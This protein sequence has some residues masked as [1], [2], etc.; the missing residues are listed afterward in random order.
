MYFIGLGLLLI[1]LKLLEVGPVANWS[2]W[3]VLS[4][5]VAAVVWWAWADSTGY[6]K[7]REMDK[8]EEKKKERR[9]KNMAALG[10]EER[11]RR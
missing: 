8:I 10:Q 6:T 9:R 3:L 7:R 5:F 4:P 1:V 2:W 11:K